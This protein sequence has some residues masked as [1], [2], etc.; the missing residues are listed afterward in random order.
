MNTSTQPATARSWPVES[1][2]LRLVAAVALGAA[3][4]AAAQQRQDFSK[5]EITNTPVIGN[6][7]LLQGSGGNIGVSAGPD[8]LLVVD[9]EFLPLAEKIDAALGKL[10][11]NGLQYVVNTH[12][13][14]DHTG[15]NAYFGK[16]AR[17]VAH[18]NLRKRLAAKADVKPEELPVL[19]YQQGVSFQFNGEEVRVIGFGPG[20][21]D[22][23]SA[24]Y[25]TKANVIELGDQYVNGRFPYV[26]VANGGDVKGLLANL[27]S[28]LKWLPADA[29][30]I[31]GHGSVGTV[32]DLKGFREFVA[33]SVEV[34]QKDI[35]AGKSLEEVKKNP[36]LD[37][38]KEWRNGGRWLE[39]V[40]KSLG[41]T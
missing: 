15:G 29:K 37:K 41:K 34:V 1:R 6:I 13:H 26:D 38:H 4:N 2:L 10:G 8:G 17:I 24:V 3:L 20:H 9:D 21:T 23:D 27:D 19:T 16:K 35:A 22:G 39:A 36:F 11:T 14:G 12:I 18:A 40:F 5:V 7:Y 25:F 32:E 31:P 30:V 28:V 33:E